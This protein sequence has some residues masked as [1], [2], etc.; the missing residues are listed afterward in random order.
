MNKTMNSSQ[1]W[2]FPAGMIPKGDYIRRGGIADCE[3]FK[4]KNRRWIGTPAE[5]K[6]VKHFHNRKTR[7]YLNF[8]MVQE[9]LAELE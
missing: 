6:Q 4:P 2:T 8:D 1:R 3:H 9:G 5:V 7:R